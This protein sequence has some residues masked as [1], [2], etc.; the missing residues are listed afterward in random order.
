MNYFLAFVFITLIVIIY[1]NENV[2]TI[3]FAKSIINTYKTVLKLPYVDG[4]KNKNFLM[5]DNLQYVLESLKIN[6]IVNGHFDIDKPKIYIVNHQSWVDP[7]IMKAIHPHIYTIAKDDV[8]NESA[9]WKPILGPIIDAWNIIFYERGSKSGGS[10]VR[11]EMKKALLENKSILIFPEGTAY[12]FGGVHDFYP[13]SFE[14]AYENNFKIQP[15][16]IKYMSDITW[17]VNDDKSKIYHKD[18][19]KNIIKCAKNKVNNV[20]INVHREINPSDF[21]NPKHLMNY[22][23]Y[24]MQKEWIN[25]SVQNLTAKQ[26]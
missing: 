5:S 6:K 14:V 8:K 1:L 4:K 21:E 3:D 11:D 23:R 10:K 12:P 26:I 25:R 7:I 16:T 13:G 15:I 18:L 22:C 24:L 20:F 9:I 2:F 19:F 17:G